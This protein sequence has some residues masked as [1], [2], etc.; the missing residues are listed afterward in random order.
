[1]GGGWVRVVRSL[2]ALASLRDNWDGLGAIAPSLAVVRTA[3]DV[4]ERQRDGEMGLPATAV[5]TPAGTILFGWE[6]GQNYLEIEV[7]SPT[8]VEWMTVDQNGIAEHGS[9]PWQ[10]KAKGGNPFCS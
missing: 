1:M 4:A 8:L 7:I 5:A 9:I 10:S 6:E 2:Q 3:V